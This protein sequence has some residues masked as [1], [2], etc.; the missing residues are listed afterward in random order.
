MQGDAI[1]LLARI[2]AIA[3][4][5][6]VMSYGRPYKEPMGR[7]EIEAELARCSG[8]HFDPELVNIFLPLMEQ[9]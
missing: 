9:L 8:K 6:E 1:P 5:Y 2:T 3:D 7:D 4:A